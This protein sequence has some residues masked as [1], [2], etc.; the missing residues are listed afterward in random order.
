MAQPVWPQP[1]FLLVSRL[2][3]Y[4]QLRPDPLKLEL[5]MEQP[6]WLQVRSLSVLIWHLYEYHYPDPSRLE[7]GLELLV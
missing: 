7:L 1:Q 6:V 5:G 2:H 4:E 3:L